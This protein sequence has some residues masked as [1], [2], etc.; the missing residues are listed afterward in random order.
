MLNA[1]NHPQLFWLTSGLE[2]LKGVARRHQR[3][4]A[5]VNKEQR[6][7]RNL[8]PTL[9]EYVTFR[10]AAHSSSDDPSVYRPKEESE[11]WP[12]GDPIERLKNHLIVKKIWTEERHTQ[13]LAEIE[14]E[15]IAAQ[16]EAESYGTLHTGPKASPRDMFADV[17]KQMP[18]HLRRQRQEA[19]F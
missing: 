1:I 17:F 14:A 19:G 15:V 8:G 10:A 11:A 18:P 16:R 2:E 5:A 4:I 7:R 9:I 13:A 3:I 6:A 12:L